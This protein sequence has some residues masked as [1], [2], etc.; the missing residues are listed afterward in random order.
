[1]AV[2]SYNGVPVTQRRS[3]GPP[4]GDSAR[5]AGAGNDIEEWKNKW[6][7]PAK[8][9]DQMKSELSVKVAGS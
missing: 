1:M 3:P 5:Q 9:K 4:G 6:S 8:Q 2:A 7:N